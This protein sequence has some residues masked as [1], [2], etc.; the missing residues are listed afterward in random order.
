[1]INPN[2]KKKKNHGVRL[3]RTLALFQMASQVGISGNIINCLYKGF[4]TEKIPHPWKSPVYLCIKNFSVQRHLNIKTAPVH[5][6]PHCLLPFTRVEL[7]FF[8]LHVHVRIFIKLYGQSA[9]PYELLCF[10]MFY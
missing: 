8:K 1:M 4:I 6:T 9:F 10:Q 7:P 2:H 3:A 5:F